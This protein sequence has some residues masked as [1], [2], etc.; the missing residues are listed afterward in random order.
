[1]VQEMFKYMS[2]VR[3]AATKFPPTCWHSYDEQFRMRQA[4][5]VTNW[6]H[7]N[8]DLWLRIMPSAAY[9]NPFSQTNLSSAYSN[10]CTCRFFNK[11][12]CTFY[13]CNF[14]H[15]CDLCG[16]TYYGMVNCNVGKSQ[17]LLF[18]GF[19]TRANR[20]FRRWLTAR[21]R[22]FQGGTRF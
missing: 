1:M 5:V 16:S 2:V 13:Q 14:R 21:G 9:K 17:C 22:Y 8:S 19:R 7:I 4:I 15:A 12:S 11:G 3:D 18:H 10:T 20:G 6:S